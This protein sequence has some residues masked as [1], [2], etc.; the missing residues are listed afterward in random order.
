MA[1]KKEAATEEKQGGGKMKL[2]I[3]AVVVL[4]L[5]VGVGVG[6]YML[7]ASG[8]GD[9]GQADGKTVKSKKKGDDAPD[10]IG[11]LVTMEDWS[12]GRK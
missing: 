11:P 2:I 7:G 1:D 3:I 10:P 12:T 5:L 8:S 9:D 6:A 4:L